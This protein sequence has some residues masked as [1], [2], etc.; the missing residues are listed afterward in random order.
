[1]RRRAKADANQPEI[2]KAL[3]GRGATVLMT[4]QLSSGQTQCGL[5]LLVGYKKIDVRME[6][7]DGSKPP[8]AQKLTPAEQNECD[9]WKGR[10]IE[11]VT[12]VD[13]AMAVLD[14]MYMEASW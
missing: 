12:S 8:S 11:I 7:K 14:K 1:M 2:V 9:T 3:R 6:I 13:D 4:H 10:K 5:D